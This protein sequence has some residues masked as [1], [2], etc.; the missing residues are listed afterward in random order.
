MTPIKLRGLKLLEGGAQVAS[1]CPSNDKYP[2]AAACAL[3]ASNKINITFFTHGAKDKCAGCA[4][5]FCTQGSV[6]RATASLIE[7]HC[8]LSGGIRLQDDI[9][10]L[11]VFPHD[12]RPHVAGRLLAAMAGQAI[13]LLGLAS[14]PAAVSAV[15]RSADTKVTIDALFN[16]FEFPAYRSP[17][18]WYAAYEGKEQLFRKI[19]AAYQE[20]VIR[21]YDI[22]QR[23][24]LDLWS[25]VLPATGLENLGG[26][27][28]ALG[29]RGV[30]MPFLT[31]LPSQ[32]NLRFSFCFP[33]SRAAEI[34]C[35][36]SHHLGTATVARHSHTTAVLIH[37]PHFGDRY[38][39]AHTLLSALQNAGITP[40]AMGCAVSS[41][42]VIIE[43]EDLA[44][45]VQALDKTFQR[46]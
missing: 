46:S 43:S 8:G 25:A 45:A 13:P 29:L 23:S 39:I 19:I 41:I 11:S 12:Q 14:S 4:I 37:G 35:A 26:V 24:G 20:K 21:I 9:A 16:A 15:V 7:T 3:L 32:D 17:S 40:L 38:G 2:A 5:A 10:V 27:L 30:R 18:D 22:V 42:S 1:G 44:K 31:A 34:R 28:T 33:T 36:F 6:A